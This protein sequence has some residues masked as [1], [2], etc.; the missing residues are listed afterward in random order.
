MD[1]KP[2]LY[3]STT[4]EIAVHE[5]YLELLRH[6]PVPS[7]HLRLQTRQGETFVIASGPK[8]APVLLLFHG[9]AA[10][11]AMWI[12]DIAAWAAHFRVYAVDMT[13]EAGFSAPSR[14]PLNSDA[15]ALWLEDVLNALGITRAS[16]VGVSLGGWLALDYAIR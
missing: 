10:N 12:G 11:S 14:P 5:R 9:G 1:K 15:C 13:G 6:W 4:G 16:M 8:A 2:S 7:E 3:K